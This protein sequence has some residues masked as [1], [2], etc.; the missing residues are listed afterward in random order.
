MK[1]TKGAVKCLLRGAVHLNPDVNAIGSKGELHE[2]GQLVSDG[3][4]SLRPCPLHRRNCMNP[5]TTQSSALV[6][7]NAIYD[8]PFLCANERLVFLAHMRS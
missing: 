3:D 6:G 4:E 5:P 7:R 1:V 2:A 8:I